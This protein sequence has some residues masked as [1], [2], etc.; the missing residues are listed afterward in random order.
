MSASPNGTNITISS[1]V[2][3]ARGTSIAGTLFGSHACQNNFQLCVTEVRSLTN[4]W[5][6]STLLTLLTLIPL[7]H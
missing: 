1:D 5:V 6:C 3:D 7:R 4:F 2:D